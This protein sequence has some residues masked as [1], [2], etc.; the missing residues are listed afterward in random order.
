MKR[1]LQ[2]LVYLL[3]A[4]SFF[5]LSFAQGQNSGESVYPVKLDD[6]EAVYLTSEKFNV[7]ADGIGDDAPAIQAAIDLVW[8]RTGGGI[9]FIP[10]GTYRLGKTVYVWRGI[11]LIGYG[12]ERPVFK[13]GENTPGYQE[14]DH[15]YM[16]HY[17]QGPGGAGGRLQPG[18]WVT[19]VFQDGT[20]TTFYSG[21][22]NINFEIGDGNP[23][24]IA[25]RYHVAQVCVL[26]HVNFNIGN[27]LGGIQA[28]GNII[29]NCTFQGGEFGIKT[30]KSAPSWQ[31]TVLECSFE[32][33]REASIITSDA[34]MLV[35]R[36]RFKNTPIGIFLPGPDQIYVKDTWFEDV[37]NTAFQINHYVHEDLQVNFDN[38]KF[39][40][41]PYSVKF[42]PRIHQ[43]IRRAGK[44]EYEAPAP[45]YCLKEFSQG[46]HIE[47]PQGNAVL[48][49]FGVEIDE[50]PIETLGEFPKSEMSEL[51][52]ADT[53]VNIK[54]LGAKGD[55]ETDDTRI[56]EK[57]IAKHEAIYVPMGS[58]VISR[59]LTLR[60]KTTMI[61]LHPSR[62]RFVLS[63]GTE[64]FQDVD[65]P[66][67]LLITPEGGSN[68]ITGIGFDLGINPGSVG[69]KWMAGFSSY[70]NDGLFKTSSRCERGEGST[71]SIWVTD[72]GSGTFK[73]IWIE[74]NNTDIPFYISK[75]KNPGNIYE[76]SI[77]HHKYHELVMDEVEN[78]SFYGLQL[79]ENTGSHMVLAVELEN[80]KN[81]LFANLRSHRTSGVWEPYHAGVLLRNSNEIIIKGN[82]FSGFVF[83]YDNTVFDEST[84]MAVPNL[85]FTKLHVR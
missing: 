48:R 40:N 78:W 69:L 4:L 56:F 20:Y 58:F 65:D 14:G 82:C 36:G 21:L 70:Y 35:I 51:P 13:L 26:D 8:E 23:A 29:E 24:A 80:C 42:K 33:Q 79:E 12:K 49:H 37:G 63:N 81:I 27:G 11:R 59:S 77:E 44:V 15:K 18:A 38:L 17:C 67:P 64:G 22:R 60:D 72:G 10:E 1:E 16:V 5:L 32:G 85:K 34:K 2:K 47:N 73:N 39:S 66:R 19:E 9:V 74:D 28:A 3:F 41:V 76:I 55:G 52:S 68:G 43:A 83:P 6:P 62:T 31:I 71:H 54:D 61:G 30:G 75:T 84:G 46:V 53:W 7:S 57:A 45:V 50:S 25:L